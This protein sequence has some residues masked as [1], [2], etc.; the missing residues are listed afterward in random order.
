MKI[1]STRKLLTIMVVLALIIGAGIFLAKK[2]NGSQEQKPAPV[3]DRILRVKRP[4]NVVVQTAT[5]RTLKESFTLPGTLEAWENL[6]LSL[7]Q[8][9]VILWVGPKEGDRLS[10]GDAILKI[11]KELLM[12]R[13]A[14]NQAEYDLKKKQLKRV[15]ALF[16]EKLVSERMLDEAKQAYESAGSL[17]DQSAIAIEKSTLVSPIDGI[18]DR[19]LV[20]R[21]EYGNVGTPAAVVVQVDRLKLLVNVPEKDVLFIQKGEAVTVFP[22]GVNGT[23]SPGIKG[24][25]I[26]VGYQA[27][28][29]T[30]TYRTKIRI[31][32]RDGAYRPGMIV[33]VRFIRR[34]LKDVL[35]VPLYAV[36]D[37]D[38][39]KFVFVVEN[40]RAVKHSVRLGSVIDGRVIVQSGLSGGEQLVVK[41]Q[42]LIQDGGPVN[43]VEG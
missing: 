31:D 20:D 36:V 23:R 38:G 2:G 39:E 32:N 24:K 5:P 35:A 7:E 27:D 40:G 6:T 19:L 37:R 33:R 15:E 22:A 10:A 30:R 3:P 11:D 29:M 26:N 13:R 34:L 9:G 18:L 42:Q 1:P 25:V 16:S 21:G 17:L 8:P 28:P 14:R 43:V 4:V 41:G 12:S